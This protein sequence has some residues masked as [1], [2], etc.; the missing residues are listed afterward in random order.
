MM[1]DPTGI[2]DV[3]ALLEGDVSRE[4]MRNV[5]LDDLAKHAIAVRLSDGAT[6]SIHKLDGHTISFTPYW[7]AEFTRRVSDEDIALMYA[8]VVHSHAE[9]QRIEQEIADGGRTEL[10]LRRGP[11]GGG[12]FRNTKAEIRRRR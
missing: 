11:A 1:P 12:S 6:Y 4:H 5:I 9:T 8:A 10:G 3:I 2:S 7:G